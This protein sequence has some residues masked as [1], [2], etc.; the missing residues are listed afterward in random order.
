MQVQ[1]TVHLAARSLDDFIPDHAD[2]GSL[3][4]SGTFLLRPRSFVIIGSLGELTGTQ[5]GPIPDKVR[6]FELF[7]RNLQEPEVITFDELLACAEWHVEV[8]EAEAVEEASEAVV[9]DEDGVI[10]SDYD[11]L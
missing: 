4:N 7:R 8:A 6:S 11:L 10:L 1:Q 9:A 2:D 3:L 5:D